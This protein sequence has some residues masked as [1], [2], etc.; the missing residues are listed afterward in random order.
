LGNVGQDFTVDIQ[1]TNA[2][3]LRPNGIR[4]NNG[5]ATVPTYSFETDTDT[6]MYYATNEVR[7][8]VGGTERLAVNGAGPGGIDVAG[9]INYTGDIADISDR[10]VKR[11]IRE[12]DPSVSADVVRALKMRKF[13]KRLNGQDLSTGQIG[14]IAQQAQVAD[15]GLVTNTGKN[16]T[17]AD[18]RDHE[19]LLAVNQGRLI[20]HLLGAVQDLQS[21]IQ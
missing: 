13:D 18:D 1:S 6:G 8:S 9:D 12:Y 3:P 10:R 4:V 21:R 16:F 11:K 19:G 15:P 7:F 5:S 17:G 14:I 2:C 20:M